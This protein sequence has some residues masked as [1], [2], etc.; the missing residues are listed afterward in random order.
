MLAEMERKLP[1]LKDVLKAELPRLGI[2]HKTEE[3]VKM[4]NKSFLFFLV[5]AFIFFNQLISGCPGSV[6][7]HTGFLNRI[8]PKLLC[9]WRAGSLI[10][11][12]SLFGERGSRA[13][14]L[15]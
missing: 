7:L 9:L 8:K 12:A 6:L 13:L 2:G 5:S 10:A 3:R 1:N 15:Q 4:T 11:K 14:G